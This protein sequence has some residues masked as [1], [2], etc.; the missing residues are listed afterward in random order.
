MYFPKFQNKLSSQLVSINAFNYI[1]L[2]TKKPARRVGLVFKAI[3][4]VCYSSAPCM[5][6]KDHSHHMITS[7]K[8]IFLHPNPPTFLYYFC[9]SC[10]GDLVHNLSQYT[11]RS[12]QINIKGTWTLEKQTDTTYSCYADLAKELGTLHYMLS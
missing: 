4:L 5:N 7:F 2:C 9:S 1:S 6:R 8:H 12:Q 10:S 11:L 3:N